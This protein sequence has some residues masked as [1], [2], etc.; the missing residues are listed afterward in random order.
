MFFKN[1]TAFRIKNEIDVLSL[2]KNLT[3][4]SFKPIDG[5]TKAT[6]GFVNPLIK[7]SEASYHSL[8]NLLVFC[9]QK[10]EKI[11]PASVINNELQN[12]I[13]DLEMAGKTIAKSQ[14]TEMKE[15]IEQQ[16][17]PQ[18]FSNYKKLFGYF[19]FENK[20]LVFN[21]A[22]DK[23]IDEC[24]ELLRRCCDF[25][26][27]EPIIEDETKLL[28]DW[29]INNTHSADIELGDKFKVVSDIGKGLTSISYK[30]DDI[31]TEQ[32]KSFIESGGNVTEL[33]MIWA[34]KLSMTITS[35]LQFKTIKFL[36]TLKEQNDDS[37]DGIYKSEA[38]I[39][40]MSDAFA[41]L[42]AATDSWNI[43]EYGL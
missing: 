24:L 4:M 19:D 29:L 3:A 2:E 1:I 10:E 38:D 5:L 27:I 8:S 7:S 31:L 39:L 23:Q 12:R 18:A 26:E 17:L 11:L 41:S 42:F 25:L 21:S 30:G 9:L 37:L 22:S 34:D 43:N 33:A 13:E 16:L 36:D 40:I 28:T 20:Y 6:R 14:K 15:M 35:K 32:I